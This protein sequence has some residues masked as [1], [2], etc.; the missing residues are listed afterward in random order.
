MNKNVLIV[1][2]IL[3]VAVVL[4]TLFVAIYFGLTQGRIKDSEDGYYL[5]CYFTGNDPSEERVCFAISE[6]GYRYDTL[7]AGHPMIKQTLG[8]GCSRD[9]YVFR[10]NGKYYV[11]ATDMKSNDGWNSNHAMIIFES[12]DL[13]NWGNE[14]VIDIKA[15]EGYEATCRTWAPQVIYDEKANKYMVYWSHCLETNWETYMVWAYLNDDF[16]DIGEIHTLYQ[17]V[18]KKDAIDG[19]IVYENGT[20]YL[21]Y[22]DEKESEICYV[23]SNTLT[24]PYSGTEGNKVSLSSQEVEGSCMYRLLGTDTYL[25]IMDQFHKDGKYYMQST[26]IDSMVKFKKVRSSAFK[27]PKGIRHASVMSITKDEYYE[28]KNWNTSV[29]MWSEE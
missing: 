26:T 20:Y 16:T 24:G 25:M 13:I 21:Y 11:I 10:A 7:N 5:L 3:V 19:D 18:S 29:G 14:R 27:F 2:S 1:V 6:D 23:T 12:N 8:T 4:L 15:K 28:L 17:P 22:K 9:P